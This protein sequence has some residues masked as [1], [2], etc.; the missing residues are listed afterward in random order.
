MRFLMLLCADESTPQSGYLPG[1][2]E[3]SK[4]MAER[5]VLLDG[6]GLHPPK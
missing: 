6:M 5:G 1:C 4:Q 2:D 3:W